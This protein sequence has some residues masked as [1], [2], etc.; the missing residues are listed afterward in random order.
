MK[1]DKN[2]VYTALNADELKPGD[3]VF[4]ADTI[5]YLK[6]LVRHEEHILEIDYIASEDSMSRFCFYSK[7]NNETYRYNLAYLVE[8][9]EK[10]VRSCKDTDEMKINKL[11][12]EIKELKAHCRT[13]DDVNAKMKNCI[14]CKCSEDY[15]YYRHRKCFICDSKYSEWELK[16][17]EE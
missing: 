11:E 10:K 4:L 3:K 2:R 16:D 15:D 6:T 9:A 7:E 1:F 12:N 17:E 14:N 5:S 8:R 13:V